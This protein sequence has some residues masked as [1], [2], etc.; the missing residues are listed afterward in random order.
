LDRPASRGVAILGAAADG[1]LAGDAS[2][3]R[4]D[5]AQQ[6]RHAAGRLHRHHDGRLLIDLGPTI[7]QFGTCPHSTISGTVAADGQTFTGT[8]IGYFFKVTP[9]AGCFQTSV[10]LHGRAYLVR[11]RHVDAGENCDDGNL[12]DGD[13]CTASCRFEAMGAPCGGGEC[14]ATSCDG[15]G[16]CVNQPAT[17]CGTICRPGTCDAGSCVLGSAVPEG[18]ACDSR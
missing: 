5:G 9:P 10:A 1:A 7:T 13:C 14:P 6:R 18:T 12:V 15:A 11:Q 8:Q 17:I 2:R 16:A 4:R 3:Y